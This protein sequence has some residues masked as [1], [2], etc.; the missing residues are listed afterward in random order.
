MVRAVREGERGEEH[1]FP[2]RRVLR[3]VAPG[4]R[5]A[6][7]G[8]RGKSGADSQAQTGQEQ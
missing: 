3:S 2:P 8:E 7:R 4:R 6:Q 5:T 1:S